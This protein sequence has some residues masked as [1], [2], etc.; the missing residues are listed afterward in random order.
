AYSPQ[1]F[2]NRRKR[3]SSP[4]FSHSIRLERT[5]LALG[6]V[7]LHK[8]PFALGQLVGR[9]LL[10]AASMLA[11]FRSARHVCYFCYFLSPAFDFSRKLFKNLCYFLLLSSAGLCGPFNPPA[12]PRHGSAGRPPPITRYSIDLLAFTR[13]R[14]A[15][16]SA[17]DL[18][19]GG[20]PSTRFSTGAGLR[21]PGGHPSCGPLHHPPGPTNP[22]DEGGTKDVTT[23]RPRTRGPT[24]RGPASVRPR[25]RR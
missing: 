20:P 6:L 19:T 23:A 14:C 25:L 2:I 9:A 15:S 3:A 11:F 1:S 16:V 4:S 12:C 7:E 18:A 21:S 24:R 17:L 8:R 22:N 10:A 13:C 5:H